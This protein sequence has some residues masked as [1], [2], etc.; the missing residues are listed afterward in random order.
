MLI[1]V[2]VRL[3]LLVF[4]LAQDPILLFFFQFSHE[5]LIPWFPESTVNDK[6][7]LKPSLFASGSAARHNSPTEIWSFTS[8]SQVDYVPYQ[9]RRQNKEKSYILFL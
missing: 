5:H 6:L 9:S 7:D 8:E 2:A 4:F 3:V 1:L